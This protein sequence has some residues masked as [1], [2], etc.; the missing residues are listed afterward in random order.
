MRDPCVSDSISEPDAWTSCCSRIACGSCWITSGRSAIRARPARSG[1]PLREVL[2][3]V[4]CASIAGC[5]DYDEIADLG[6]S[7]SRLPRPLRRASLRHAQ[8]RLAAGGPQALHRDRPQS[9][10]MEPRVPRS[11][12]PAPNALTWTRRPHSHRRPLEMTAGFG[13]MSRMALN[14]AAHGCGCS[15]G[16]E[17]NLAKVG[18]EGSNPFA[19]S[20]CLEKFV[21]RA[22]GYRHIRGLAECFGRKTSNISSNRS[23]PNA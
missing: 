10:R 23:R 12:H 6:R 13:H 14:G 7:S 11:T 17:H 18:V 19:R 21:F 1:I 2:F 8:G 9:C 3:L 22:N 15:S 20:K 4:T 5:D 16:V